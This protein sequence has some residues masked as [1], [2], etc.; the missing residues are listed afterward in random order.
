MTLLTTTPATSA[1]PPAA[2]LRLASGSNPFVCIALSPDGK[3]LASGGYEKTIRIW[4]LATGK[5]VRKWDSP[6]GNL[7]SLVFSPDG[8]LLASGGV[9]DKEVHLW[10]SATG[11]KVLT[12]REL[13]RGTS[14]LAFSPEG[15]T[16]AAGGYHT[17]EVYLWSVA[18]G[19][20][21]GQLAGPTVAMPEIELR[22]RASPDFSHVVFAPDGETLASG[23]A[24]G[25]IRIWDAATGREQRHFRGPVEDVFTHVAYSSAGRVL[26]SW[27]ASIRLRQTG[28][29]RLF[30]GFGEQPALRISTVAFSPDGK[31]LAS[32]SSGRTIGDSKV[33]L[34]EVAS[35]K[36]RC[37]LVGHQYAVSAL[38]FTPD[39]TT[40]VS[41]SL[42]GVALV[43][44]LTK[45]PQAGSTK[46]NPAALGLEESWRDLAG[47]D[48]ARAYR[49]I[50]ALTQAE[51]R[52]VLLFKERLRPVTLATPARVEQLISDLDSRR[53]KDRQE[54]TEELTLQLE[55][56]EPILRKALASRP[57]PE[58]RQRLELVLRSK[59][60]GLYS[61][62][63][64]MLLRCIEVLEHIATSDAREVLQKVA[65]G[66]PQFRITREAKEA[67]ER[68]ARRSSGAS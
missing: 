14:S 10:E 65:A 37:Q 30:P 35:G 13:P 41:G 32:G 57:S 1:L 5:E 27:G 33:H 50:Q 61:G 58:S 63:N 67:L 43:W 44:D 40:L 39:G 51:D 16:L 68:L 38:A 62:R 24:H 34:W 45:L 25:L 47:S 7:A 53:F 64:L 26:A 52:T 36:E 54:A 29:W 9:F 6:E 22:G 49:A 11:K 28:D 4:E 3:W 23:H 17:D 66:T 48:P 42:D 19:K 46:P 31:M 15:K 60:T 55:L 21:I 20:P 59:D 8:R 18:T 2:R 12:L 56:I